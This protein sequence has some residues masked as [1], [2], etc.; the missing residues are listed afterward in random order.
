MTPFQ[1][2]RGRDRSPRWRWPRLAASLACLAALALGPA[3]DLSAGCAGLSPSALAPCCCH[4]AGKAGVSSCAKC[5]M[6]KGCEA[7]PAR[8]AELPPVEARAVMAGGATLPAPLPGERVAPP[9]PRFV[10]SFVATLD[11]PPPRLAA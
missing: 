6:C 4:L 9:A 1:P 3:A 7:G 2:S 5:P 10:T 8:S 11:P